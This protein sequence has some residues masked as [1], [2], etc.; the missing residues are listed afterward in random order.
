MPTSTD[1]NTN[2]IDSDNENDVDTALENDTPLHIHAS[3]TPH[4]N[5]NNNPTMSPQGT[6]N[7]EDLFECLQRANRAQKLVQ[8]CS[9]TSMQRSIRSS[10]YPT[11][12]FTPLPQDDPMQYT[13]DTNKDD[14]LCSYECPEHYKE[15]MLIVAELRKQR[16]LA[17]ENFQFKPPTISRDQLNYPYPKRS[18]VDNNVQTNYNVNTIIST[19]DYEDI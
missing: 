17:L 15:M 4:D 14:T 16:H 11:E 9:Q 7:G 2:A 6:T 3:S 12:D 1:C 19:C 8:L 5:D 18:K 13:I 10:E